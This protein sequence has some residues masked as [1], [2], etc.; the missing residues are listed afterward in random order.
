MDK[1]KVLL[2]DDQFRFLKSLQNILQT[3]SEDI[4]VVG[5]ASNGK[6]ALDM[7]ETLQ[8]DIILMDVRM[9]EMNGVECTRLIRERFPK[10]RVLMLTTFDDDEYVIEALHYG[11]VG[12]LLK[13]VP[14]T[15]LIAAIRAVYE[16]GV[17]IAPQVATKLV[18]KLRTPT[19]EEQSRA[20][21]PLRPAWLDD[22]SNREKEVLSLMAKGHDN[23]EIAKLLFIGE[24]TVKNYVSLIYCKLGVHDRVQATQMANNAGLRLM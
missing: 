15:E 4:Q 18:V 21:E 2:V 19:F 17:L 6:I 11:A 22:L 16:G 1:I 24:Q 5:V 12:F 3:R 9:P 10:P 20:N 8:P 7:V 23:K 13:D 14:P